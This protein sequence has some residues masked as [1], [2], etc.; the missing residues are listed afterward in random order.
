MARS[1]QDNPWGRLKW[2]ILFTAVVLAYGVAGYMLLEGWSFLDALYMSLISLTT[3]GYKEV[4][5]VDPSG[6]WFTVTLLLM[7]VSLV[8]V[9]LSLVSRSIAEGGLGGRGRRRR[10]QKR[11]DAMRDHFIICAYGRVGRTVARECEADG[12]DFVVIDHDASLEDQMIDDGVAYLIGDPSQETVLKAAGVENARGLVCA[13]DSDASNVFVAL[14]ARSL[15]PDIFIVARA[16]EASAPERLHRAGADR[17]ISPYVTS[18]RLMAHVALRPKAV[19]YVEV[20][21]PDAPALR[22]EQVQ[23]DEDSD[24]VGRTLAEASGDSVALAVCRSGGEVVKNPDAGLRLN[25]GDLLVLLA[26]S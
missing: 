21:A 1:K 9:T 3:V 18:G 19:E 10:M 14:T 26:G 4:R 6:Q 17:V 13:M 23:V 2:L 16:S 20:A 12:V 15:N 11:L 22:M 24:L 25:E 8:V 7:G 5:P